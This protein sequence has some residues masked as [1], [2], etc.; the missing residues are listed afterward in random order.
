MEKVC[1][2]CALW[3]MGSYRVGL[4]YCR[5]KAMMMTR[6][7]QSCECFVGLKQEVKEEGKPKKL[8]KAKRS[9]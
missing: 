1:S 4:G 8:K 6:S 3:M 9:T 7:F 5:R 2:N